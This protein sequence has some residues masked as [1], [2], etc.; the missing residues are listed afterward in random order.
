MNQKQVAKIAAKWWTDQLAVKSKQ[1]AGDK[2]ISIAA[3]LA[4]NEARKFNPLTAQKLAAFQ[5][6]LEASLLAF[7]QETKWPK[8]ELWRGSSLKVVKIVKVDY[9]PDRILKEA[10]AKADIDQLHFPIKTIMWLDPDGIKVSSGYGGK[11]EEITDNENDFRK[12]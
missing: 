9:D 2:S 7:I 3:S 11:I 4:E 6:H 10:A 12:V 1:D 5:S 8:E